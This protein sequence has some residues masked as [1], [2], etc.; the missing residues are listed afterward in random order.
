MLEED[1]PYGINVYI[2]K[3]FVLYL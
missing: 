2:R 1:N 3:Q